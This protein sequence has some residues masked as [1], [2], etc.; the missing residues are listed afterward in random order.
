[1]SDEIGVHRRWFLM[2]QEL[3]T[4][5]QRAGQRTTAVWFLEAGARTEASEDGL[6]RLVKGPRFRFGGWCQWRRAG[7]TKKIGPCCAWQLQ[8]SQCIVFTGESLQH[9]RSASARAGCYSHWDLLIRR[10]FLKQGVPVE[11]WTGACGHCSQTMGKGQPGWRKGIE[12][13]AKKGRRVSQ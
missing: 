1:M 7:F 8:S 10:S 9:M 13:A 2:V 11:P 6:L 3:L 5:R 4:K 12:D